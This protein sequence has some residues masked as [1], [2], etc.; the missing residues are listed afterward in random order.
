VSR[1]LYRYR[2]DVRLSEDH[3]PSGEAYIQPVFIQV[4][5]DSS[6][7]ATHKAAAIGKQLHLMLIGPL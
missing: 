1:H 4:P 2:V 5:A 6:V 3:S 7:E